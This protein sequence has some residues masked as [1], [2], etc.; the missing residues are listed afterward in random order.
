MSSSPPPTTP[1][2]SRPLPSPYNMGTPTRQPRVTSADRAAARHGVPPRTSSARHLD[3]KNRP[4]LSASLSQ[5]SDIDVAQTPLLLRK[6]SSIQDLASRFPV[7]PAPTSAGVRIMDRKIE[8]KVSLNDFLKEQWQP[9]TPTLSF[10]TE[11]PLIAK[12]S[13]TTG[14]RRQ[15]SFPSHGRHV[16]KGSKASDQSDKTLVQK[17]LNRKASNSSL[18]P[19]I[20]TNDRLRSASGVST[21]SDQTAVIHSTL[22]QPK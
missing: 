18:Q 1:N 15:A 22:S 19:A 6:M 17:L 20:T 11:Q 10:G 12:S 21:G 2:F 13:S 9:Q 14:L 8:R 4:T 5:S 16:S 7:S 3:S